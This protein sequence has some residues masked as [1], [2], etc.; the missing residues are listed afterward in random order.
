M[1]RRDVHEKLEIIANVEELVDVGN[2]WNKVKIT[3]QDKPEER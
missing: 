1:L 2:A 3:I